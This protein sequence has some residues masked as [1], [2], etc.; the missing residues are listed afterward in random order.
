MPIDNSDRL[1]QLELEKTRIE[2][3][4]EQERARARHAERKAEDRRNALL[5]AF[6]AHHVARNPKLR[7]DVE[8]NIYRYHKRKRDRDFLKAYFDALAKEAD[9]ETG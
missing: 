1:T 7:G 3:R 6:L 4:I 8:K 5:G 2:A 9:T